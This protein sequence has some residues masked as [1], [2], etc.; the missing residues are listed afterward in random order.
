[1]T[2]TKRLPAIAFTILCLTH[3][4]CMGDE[5]AL[6]PEDTEELLPEQDHQQIGDADQTS[7]EIAAAPD[8]VRLAYG[9][10][11]AID[12]FDGIAPSSLEDG[13]VPLAAAFRFLYRRT[14]KIRGWVSEYVDLRDVG[15]MCSPNW[16]RHSASVRKSSGNGDCWFHSWLTPGDPNDCRVTV[17]VKHSAGG[18]NIWNG[19]CEVK[20]WEKPEL[21]YA[22]CLNICGEQSPSGCWC[23]PGCAIY[24]DCCSDYE[25]SCR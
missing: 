2:H 7:V 9:V 4:A 25:R 23:D 15:Q 6:A 3:A 11:D 8:G 24:G 5:T 22:S 21:R 12:G 20:V 13:I 18:D 16:T 19:E 1:M 10:D 17:A 14:F